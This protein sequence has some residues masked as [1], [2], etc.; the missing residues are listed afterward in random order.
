MQRSAAGGAMTTPN[1]LPAGWLE[2]GHGSICIF[3]KDFRD[4][5]QR[6]KKLILRPW[7]SIKDIKDQLQVVFNVPSNV[8]KLYYQGRELKNAHNL[9]QCGIYMDNAV[10]DFVAR[11]AH[12]LAMLYGMQDDDTPPPTILH[13]ALQGLALGLAPVLAMD[14][15]GGTYFLKDPTHRNVGEIF[16]VNL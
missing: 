1:S 6:K 5:L 3:V 2:S 8:Q 13:Q 7:A 16:I 12:D 15:T 4:P 10:I 9:Q 14:G 11:R